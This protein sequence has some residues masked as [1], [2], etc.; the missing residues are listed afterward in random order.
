MKQQLKFNSK[1]VLL[2]VVVLT[3]IS[4]NNQ[5]NSINHNIS[6]TTQREHDS[7]MLAQTGESATDAQTKKYDH[8]KHVRDSI[9][10]L[11]N[12]GQKDVISSLAV[13]RDETSAERLLSEEKD[14]D[15]IIPLWAIHD[16]CKWGNV[17]NGSINM[18]AIKE[19]MQT[20]LGISRSSMQTWEG[21]MIKMIS[22]LSPSLNAKEKND[23]ALSLKSHSSLFERLTLLS[24]ASMEQL[25]HMTDTIATNQDNNGS[26]IY[27]ADAGPILKREFTLVQNVWNLPGLV[28]SGIIMR[29]SCYTIGKSVSNPFEDKN[30][31]ILWNTRYLN[32]YQYAIGVFHRRCRDVGASTYEQRKEVAQKIA[33]LLQKASRMLE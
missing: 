25:I 29:D 2:I 20:F 21:S 6:N 8:E 30:E 4:C 16:Y 18:D 15:G 5:N 11:I 24:A 1:I 33:S 13:T 12:T 7:D 14:K 28:K 26:W 31:T 22:Q 17:F 9:I 32:K 10:S 27:S 3:A 19:K 23:V